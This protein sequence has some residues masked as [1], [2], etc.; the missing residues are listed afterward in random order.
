VIVESGWNLNE[1]HAVGLSL[2]EIFLQ[3]TASPEDLKVEHAAAEPV[4]AES[5][6]ETK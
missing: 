1:L 6:G 4:A 3:L 2:E 5:L